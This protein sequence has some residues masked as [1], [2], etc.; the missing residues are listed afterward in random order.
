ML[1]IG[2]KGGRAPEVLDEFP[3]LTDVLILTAIL[4]QVDDRGG[5]IKTPVHVHWMSGEGDAQF[6]MGEDSEGPEDG[7]CVKSKAQEEEDD[8]KGKTGNN[9]IMIRV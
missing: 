8:C 3:H 5:N 6:G 2:D 7:P 9:R 1:G 4:G